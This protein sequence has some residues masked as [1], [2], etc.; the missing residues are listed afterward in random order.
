MM[1]TS[2]KLKKSCA[3]KGW[4][5]LLYAQDIFEFRAE[6]AKPLPIRCGP[7]WAVECGR[8]HQWRLPRP[9]RPV[10]LGGAWHGPRR[11]LAC[12]FRWG[13]GCQIAHRNEK[14]APPSARHLIPAPRRAPVTFSTH[15]L[16]LGCSHLCASFHRCRCIVFFLFTGHCKSCA[17]KATANE[18][19]PLVRASDDLRG[20][21][22]AI[23]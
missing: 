21:P 1:P 17:E 15:L 14:G 6:P 9:S 4:L 11:P 3:I 23:K 13:R 7:P 20:V 12:Y 10:Q 5:G 8:G 22:F 19:F 2:K 16:Q 18:P